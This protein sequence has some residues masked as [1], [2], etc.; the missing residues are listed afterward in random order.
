MKRG[1]MRDGSS[2]KKELLQGC[3]G[4]AGEGKGGGQVRSG[5]GT[6][7]AEEVHRDMAFWHVQGYGSSAYAGVW[8]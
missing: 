7:H 5:V 8:L 2:V 1:D 4:G 3:R 6:S